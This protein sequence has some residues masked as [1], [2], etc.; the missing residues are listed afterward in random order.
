MHLFLI[1][2]LAGH[3]LAMNLASA[4]PLAAVFLSRRNPLVNQAA[5]TLLPASI[6]SLVVGCLLGGLLLL[7]PS[8]GVAAALAR[9]P[10]RAYWFAGAELV[11]SLTCWAAMLLLWNR[12]RTGRRGQTVLGLLALAGSTNL[13]YHFPPMMGVFGKLVLD[14]RWTDV[15]VLHRP[16]L[17]AAMGRAEIVAL[18]LHF[19]IASLSVACLAGMHAI[20]RTMRVADSRL[21]T[22][23]PVDQVDLVGPL[24][25][26]RRLAQIALAI[27]LA[28]FASGVWLLT[29]VES[30]AR[31]AMLG[32][33]I[34]PTIYL[35]LGLF[36]AVKLAE[37]L[38]AAAFGDPLEEVR[39]ATWWLVVT[40]LLMSGVLWT[41]RVADEGLPANGKTS[42]PG[43]PTATSIAAFP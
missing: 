14:P 9:F 8:S 4:G 17:L 7:R 38:A 34:E 22:D 32:G 28:Q 10:A 16:E 27:T 25:S 12:C 40:V 5:R 35:G 3:L 1:L 23:E 11:F 19:A 13:L 2:L 39:G 43:G 36:G 15:Q 20:G 41:S 31:D 18:S 33:R 29:A 30:S 26:A 24:Q 42:R 37:R 21:A 6:A